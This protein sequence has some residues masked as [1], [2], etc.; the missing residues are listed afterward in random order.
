MDFKTL[1][2]VKIIIEFFNLILIHFAELSQGY[3]GNGH[4]NL[5][6]EMSEVYFYIVVMN[7][8]FTNSITASLPF[9]CVPQIFELSSIYIF[10]LLFLV[11]DDYL[12]KKP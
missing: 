10:R 9:Y 1:Y 7:F 2:F 6:V 5:L 3:T 8:P 4:A 12:P 11:I